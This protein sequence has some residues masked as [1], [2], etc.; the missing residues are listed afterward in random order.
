MK[1]QRRLI[2]KVI[3]SHFHSILELRQLLLNVNT[4]LVGLRGSPLPCAVW[5]VQSFR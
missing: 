5:D 2:K 1:N 3:R 4:M